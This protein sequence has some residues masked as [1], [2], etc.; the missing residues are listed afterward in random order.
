[1]YRL[2]RGGF[3]SRRCSDWKKVF[4]EEVASPPARKL[5]ASTHA[6]FKGVATPGNVANL[7]LTLSAISAM[8][9]AD[10]THAGEVRAAASWA[11]F[12]N[13]SLCVVELSRDAF[14]L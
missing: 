6:S 1:M 3:R 8:F 13:V 12:A 5:R 9:G 7:F 10:L 2:W 14:G 11:R 4:A